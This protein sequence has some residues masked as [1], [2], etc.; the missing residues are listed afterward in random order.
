MPPGGGGGGQPPLGSSSGGG[1][2]E[3]GRMKRASTACKEC[4]K[5]RTRCTGPPKCSECDTHDRECTFDEQ[6]DRRRK[7]NAKRTQ[8]ELASLT[9][10]TEQLLNV[11]RY[12]NNAT[13]QH[14]VNVIRSSTSREEI[15]S[16][17]IQILAQHPE[18]AQ[19]PLGPPGLPPPHQQHP[20]AAPHHV[21]NDL[22]PHNLG[23]YFDPR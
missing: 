9:E 23:P 19:Q 18:L 16:V 21:P 2:P 10:F 14:V 12:S 22:D 3:D 20:S 5:R 11:I 15:Q 4:Q 1:T 8:E 6:A 13:T 17:L 7:A